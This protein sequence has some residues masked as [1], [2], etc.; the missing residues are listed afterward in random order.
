VTFL[1]AAILVVD[2]NEDNRYTLVRRLERDGYRSLTA[3]VNGREALERL[4]ASPFDL[5]LLDV[6]MP[7]LDGIETLA[8]MKADPGLR[9]VPVIMISAAA[10]L[11]RVARCIELGAEDYLPKP[12]NRVLLRARVGACLERKRLHDREAAHLA[13]IEAQRR[14]ADELLHVILPAPAVSELKASQVV[15]PRR[16]D[17]VVV[18][19]ADVVGFTAFCESRAPEEVVANLDLLVRSFEDL[20]ARHGLEKIKTT[21]DALM[22]TAGLLVETGDPVMAALRCA[23]ASVDAARGLPSPWALRVGVHVGPVVS[24]IVGRQ[25]FSFDLWGDTVNVAARLAAH[26]T[27]PGVHLSPAAWERVRARVR[28]S[29]LGLVH[30]KGKGEMEVQRLDGPAG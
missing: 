21:G 13:E 30:V 8:R 6:M 25:K 3:A 24:G 29:S 1:D 22:A 28:V 4:A 2:D 27:S 17:D 10:D 16:H 5:V 11:D 20:T 12:F 23:A 14:R 15:R 19:I 7:E 9:H 26:G 18:L